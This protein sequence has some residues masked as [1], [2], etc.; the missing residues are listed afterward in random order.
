MDKIKRKALKATI[1]EFFKT[2]RII[3]IIFWVNLIIGFIVGSLLS[4]VLEVPHWIFGGA[5]GAICAVV[6]LCVACL[7]ACLTYYGEKSL[8][9]HIK[10]KPY[11]NEFKNIYNKN[12]EEIMKE[13]DSE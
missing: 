12:K 10:N 11:L 9:F 1:K 3:A 4:D 8:I 13:E 2:D 5:I 7:V 6:L